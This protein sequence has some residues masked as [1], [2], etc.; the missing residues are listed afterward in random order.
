M[1]VNL[2][3]EKKLCEMADKLSGNIQPS[4]YKT[5]IR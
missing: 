1:S 4:E 5:V 3:F 2:E